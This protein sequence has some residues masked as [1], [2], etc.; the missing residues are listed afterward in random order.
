MSAGGNK[1]HTKLKILLLLGLNNF[2]IPNTEL[3]SLHF[4]FK[5]PHI[6]SPLLDL[7]L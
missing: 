7:N 3:P 1:E 2:C 6:V 4:F 5:E